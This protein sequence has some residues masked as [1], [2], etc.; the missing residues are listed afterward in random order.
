MIGPSYVSQPLSI[1]ISFADIVTILLTA[2]TIILGFLG[3][4]IAVLAFRTKDQIEK[5]AR[6]IA[7]STAKVTADDATR[8]ALAGIPDIIEQQVRNEID[9]TLDE[10]L[11]AA[12]AIF[13]NDPKSEKRV[14][15]I[16][17]RA[18]MRSAMGGEADE[19]ESD[20]K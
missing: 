19:G 6:D 18:F 15:S 1:S 12:I 20:G 8:V 14:N 9:S 16:M 17:E 10:A 13:L 2:L 5:D 7:A 3:L 4:G 11:S